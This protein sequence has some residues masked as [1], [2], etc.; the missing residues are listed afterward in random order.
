[1]KFS[2]KAKITLGFWIAILLLLL[3]GWLSY[4]ATR[5]L[6]Q[7]LDMM[8]QTQ[9]VI[10]TL[11]ATLACLAQVESEQ[12]GFLLTGSAHFLADSETAKAQLAQ[13][14]DR[15]RSLMTENPSQQ[16]YLRQ[17]ETLIAQRLK[18][19]V[20]RIEV[21]R[22]SGWN[23]VADPV[24]LAAGNEVMDR[25]RSLIDEMHEEETRRLAKQTEA[26]H[27]ETHFNIAIIGVSSALA[28]GLGMLA[29]LRL[30]RDL[31][32][33]AQAEQELKNNQNLLE[34]I[35]DH[36]PAL[37]FLKD[38][39]GRYLFVNRH[40]AE[41]AGRSRAEIKGKTP[42]DLSPKELAQTAAEHQK[43]VL[44]R[45]APV[46]FEEMVQYA[47]GPR[48]HL[49]VKFPLRDATGKIYATAGISTDIS[50]RR[51][52]EAERDRF[53]ALSLDLLCIASADGYFKRVSPAV[54]DL[55]GWSAEE[56][57]ARPYLEQVHPDDQEATRQEVE[58]Q[59]VRGERV[60]SFE[61]RYRHKDGSWRTLSWRSMP[62]GELMY[63]IARDVTEVK[64]AEEEIRALNLSL[65]ARAAQLE[66]TNK[67][68]EAFSYSVSHDLR[69]P[70]RHI[71][72]FVDLLGK[73]NGDKLDERGQRYLK[74][75][76]GAARQMGNLIDDLLI[77]SRMGRVE[78]RQ[79]QVELDAL[80]HE[81]V[82]GMQPDLVG[83]NIEWQI[84]QLP[85]VTADA[86]MLRQVLVNLIA[87]A[88]KYSRPRNPARIEIGASESA[89]E[90]VFFVR[91]NGVGFDMEYV[92]KLFGVFQRLHRAEEFEGT[93]IGLANVQRIIRRHGG[94]VWAEGKID[95]GATFYFTL[96][97]SQD[98]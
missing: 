7:T 25:I 30:R 95:A 18:L 57:L 29:I 62:Q 4:R 73:Q 1:M 2:L 72:G 60:L 34:S 83:R 16:L 58:K 36:T 6:T 11:E 26:A 49:A 24:V 20:E 42:F 51:Q 94:R 89:L 81:A 76:T 75:I 10:G 71:D 9:E 31:D 74:I 63:A 96:P 8:A 68:L 59:V 55:L 53:F 61:N 21:F 82:A 47:D 79:Q 40:F 92:N 97:R 35:L 38:L 54:T 23:A 52:A 39:D 90:S 67:E 12:R 98:E 69:A 27:R 50:A 46:E 77:F 41:V 48:R 14:M 93:G 65:N 86:A 66:A 44:S 17:L 87:N 19:L 91:D 88:I 3:T 56:F 13:Q 85:K 5:Q 15:L 22:Q 28:V 43:T 80:V 33:R 32:L 45:Q 84:G 78:L 70:L 37:V 64:R